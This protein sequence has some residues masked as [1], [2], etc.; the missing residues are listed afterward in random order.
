MIAHAV[1]YGS[2]PEQ[3]LLRDELARARSVPA[4]GPGFAEIRAFR[5]RHLGGGPIG[6]RRGIAG[7]IGRQGEAEGPP[8]SAY[9]RVPLRGAD[10]TI[11]AS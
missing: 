8:V 10:P 1:E 4:L 5:D 2:L 11:S 3:Q 6:P 9:L 7:W